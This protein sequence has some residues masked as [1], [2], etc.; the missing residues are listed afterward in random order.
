MS[1]LNTRTLNMIYRGVVERI[2]DA[3]GVQVVAVSGLD[4][5]IKDN[6]ERVQSYGHSSSPMPGSEVIVICPGGDRSAAVIVATDDRGSRM[7]GLNPG[8]VAVYTQEGDSIVLGVNNEITITTK[9][10]IINAEE[11]VTVNAQNRI[12]LVSPIVE[13]NP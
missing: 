3:K 4:G 13:I 12:T 11:T 9:R 1:V 8:E 2:D 10:L 5:E 7:T 6:V